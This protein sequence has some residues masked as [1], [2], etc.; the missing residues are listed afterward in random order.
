[1]LSNR[2]GKGACIKA[3]P[4]RS[5]ED[6]ARLRNLLA[7]RPRDR[8]LF[9]IGINTPLRVPDLLTL[10]I[11]QVRCLK[12]GEVLRLQ[13]QRTP[14][15]FRVGFNRICCEAVA[16]LLASFA[17]P[18]SAA[19]VEDASYLFRSQRGAALLTTSLNRLVK[20]WCQRIGL[21]GN[22]GAHSLRKTWG[23]HQFATFGTDLGRLMTYFNHTSRRQTLDY[24][25]LKPNDFKNIFD[26]M[27]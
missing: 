22:Y 20:S 24:L 27:L 10:K 18:S 9:A 7:D 21:Q 4:I 16:T 26:H 23:Y 17:K 6:I 19:D 2:P 1:M 3:E 15:Q 11:G 12:P 13:D 14:R 8:A 5:L 25:C